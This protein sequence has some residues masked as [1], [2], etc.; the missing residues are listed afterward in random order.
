MGIEILSVDELTKSQYLKYSKL[1]LGDKGLMKYYLKSAFDKETSRLKLRRNERILSIT[2]NDK[3]IAWVLLL[4]F[5]A[6]YACRWKNGI[7]IYTRAKYRGKGYASQLIKE[8][9]AITLPH[10]LYC[11]G[12]TKFFNKYGIKYA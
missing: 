12:N 7:H 11:R 3:V 1:T 5:R 2:E 9:I 4:E 10:M 6:C 8:A